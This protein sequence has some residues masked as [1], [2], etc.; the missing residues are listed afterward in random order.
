M[1]LQAPPHG[2]PFLG[3][4]FECCHVYTRIY[5]NQDRTAYEGR[6][7]HCLRTVRVRIDPAGSAD[8]FF[9]AR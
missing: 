7:P 3:I 1:V 5:R 6:C 9:V 4:L 2:R 8:R